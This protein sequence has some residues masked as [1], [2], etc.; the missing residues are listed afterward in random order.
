VLGRERPGD[1]DPD[2]PDALIGALRL[3]TT[4]RLVLG[5]V[6]TVVCTK[7]VRSSAT[8]LGWT[9]AI[10]TALYVAGRTANFL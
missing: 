3:T 8:S 2:P 9:L 4:D 10:G 6:G 7:I 1:V 5:L